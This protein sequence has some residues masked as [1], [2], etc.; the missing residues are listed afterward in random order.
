MRYGSW[1]KS[2]MLFY[3]GQILS[4][5]G[6]GEKFPVESDGGSEYNPREGFGTR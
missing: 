5:A 3:W 2:L 6:W 1:N 4:W